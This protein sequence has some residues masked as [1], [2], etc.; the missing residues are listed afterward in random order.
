LIPGVAWGHDQAYFFEEKVE[1]HQIVLN[2]MT[3][4]HALSEAC[5]AIA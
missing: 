3:D 4:S 5:T 1:E 2:F